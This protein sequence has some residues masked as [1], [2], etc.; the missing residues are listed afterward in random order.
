M[1]FTPFH[2][3]FPD[4]AE[5]E[6]RT[7]TI[8]GDSK[9]PEDTYAL[10]ESYCDEP[11]CDCRRVF[12]TIVATQAARTVATIGYGWEG[13]RFYAKWYGEDDPKAIREIKGPTLNRLSRQS[14]VAQAIREMF[15]KYILQDKKYV[16]RLKHHYKMFREAVEKKEEK[17]QLQ[18]MISKKVRKVSP[19]QGDRPKI[20]RN[21]PCPC[22]SGKKYKKCC[23]NKDEVSTDNEA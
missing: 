23:L 17:K 1:A 2:E 13:E 18:K 7:M 11:G 8:L 10:V 6:T 19:S 15:E 9:V 4:I 14:E 20:G 16:K 12:F 22:G 3:Y 5:T 21:A